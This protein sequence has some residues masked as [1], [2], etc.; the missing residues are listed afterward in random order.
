M[1]QIQYDLIFQRLVVLTQQ[2]PEHNAM[3]V[4]IEYLNNLYKQ[5]KQIPVPN[6]I[7][8]FDFKLRQLEMALNMAQNAIYQS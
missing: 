1:T 8:N 2:T 3:T 6:Q 4:K 7:P 5:V